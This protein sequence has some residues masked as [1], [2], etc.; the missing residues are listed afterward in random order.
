MKQTYSEELKNNLIAQMLPPS[1]R[2][3]TEL[4]QETGIPKETLY[5][6]RSKALGQRKVVTEIEGGGNLSSADK[7]HFV[8]E[9]A[10]LNALELGEFCRRRGLFPEQLSAWRENCIAANG[11]HPRREKSPETHEL[12]MENRELQSELRR[13]EKALA[14]A[15]ALLV[16]QKKVRKLWEGIEDASSSS[17]NDRR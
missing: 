4:A 16:L 6:W 15:A 9:S 1:S 12:L 7:F 11:I 13:K 14:E 8:V 3:I 17:R 5:S 2:S 10:A